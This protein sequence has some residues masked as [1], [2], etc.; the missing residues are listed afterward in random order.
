VIATFVVCYLQH[1]VPILIV[2]P[3]YFAPGLAVRDFFVTVCMLRFLLI[4]TFGAS[5]LPLARRVANISFE[6]S[7]QTCS[8]VLAATCAC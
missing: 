7:L 4:A 2:H 6:R 8:H 3:L 1:V 5:W